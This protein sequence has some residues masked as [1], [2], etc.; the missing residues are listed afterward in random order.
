[1]FTTH[2][3]TIKLYLQKF[4]L[5]LQLA[6]SKARQVTRIL[7]VMMKAFQITCVNTGKWKS[8]QQMKL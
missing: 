2:L 3:K 8:L 6:V 4:M 7:Q 5:V 1:M